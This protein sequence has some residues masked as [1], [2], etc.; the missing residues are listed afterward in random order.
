MWSNDRPTAPGF[1]WCHQRGKTRIV[2]IWCYK[3]GTEL[4]TNEDG[5]ASIKDALY[6]GA[7]WMAA[8]NPPNPQDQNESA[9]PAPSFAD[10]YQGAMEEV[11]IWKKRALEAEELNRKFVAEINGP[12]CMGEP[13][14]PA[15]SVPSVEAA[16]AMGA[17]GAPVIE[18]ERIAFEAWMRGHC[19]KLGAEW[20]GKEYRGAH[21]N[22]GLFDPLAMHTRALWAAWRDRAALATQEVKS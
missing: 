14:Q 4:F 21:E 5:G 10:A 2:H 8:V 19:W 13:A 3:N 12:V 6:D 9:Q 17:K 7:Q 18:G 15:P 22:Q 11:A 1:Y 20:T 16:E